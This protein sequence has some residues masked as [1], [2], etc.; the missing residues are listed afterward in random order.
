M[1]TILALAW[2]LASAE[3]LALV[4]ARSGVHG[5]ALHT[6]PAPRTLHNSHLSHLSHT[7][8]VSYTQR[9]RPLRAAEDGVA[10]SE[11]AAVRQLRLV[12]WKWGWISWWP[13]IV[14]SVVSAVLLLFT[15][16]VRRPALDAA[17]LVGR[18]LALAGIAASFAGVFFTWSFTRLARRFEKKPPSIA[19]ATSRA[20]RLISISTAVNLAGMA[21]S[22]IGAECIVGT[23]AAK[24]L[25]QGATLL[26]GAGATPIQALDVL[27]VQ[28][29]T[30][31]LA[32][33]FF[34]LLASMRMQRAVNQCAASA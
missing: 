8:S 21:I 22:I 26:M 20:S 19:D 9:S 3:G 34:G 17:V 2:T 24:S 31:T 14:L 16:S 4:G 30:N 6:L 32:A 13:Q 29:N 5:Q 27:V 10:Q 11:V 12:L 18:S 7:Q 15:D 33:Q 1:R 25:T 28:A 23:L